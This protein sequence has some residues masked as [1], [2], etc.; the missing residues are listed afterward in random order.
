MQ[1]I[2]HRQTMW[3]ILLILTV[4]VKKKVFNFAPKTIFTVCTCR[5]QSGGKWQSKTLFL[6]IIDLHALIVLAFSIA[7]YPVS[8][9]TCCPPSGRL[10]LLQERMLR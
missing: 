10:C 6:T 3:L 7:T 8:F 4:N 9:I 1:N 2:T 5:R